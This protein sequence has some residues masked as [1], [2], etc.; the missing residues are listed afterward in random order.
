MPACTAYELDWIRQA[1][2]LKI[3]H[4]NIR[5]LLLNLDEVKTTLLDGTFDIVALTETWLHSQCC[6]D[7]LEVDG[8]NLYRQDRKTVTTGGC[9]KRGGGIR[10]YVKNEFNVVTLPTQYTSNPDLEST[11]IYLVSWAVIRK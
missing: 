9:V 5:S 11:H 10:I 3:F 7:L 6:N 8:F 1:K 4:L 2:G